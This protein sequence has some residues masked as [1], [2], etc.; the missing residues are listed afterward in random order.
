MQGDPKVIEYLNSALRSE[1]T[2]ISQY[3]LHYRLQDDWGLGH[4]AKKSR[5]E[6]I[7][8][9]N[10]A[11]K[12]MARIL[13]L[14]G[15]PNLQKLDPL[16][17]GQTPKETLECDLAAEQDARALYKEAREYCAEV[18]DHVTKELFDELLADEEGHIDFLET[19]LDLYGRVGDENYAL[20]NASK[21][22]EA[23]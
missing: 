16:R 2:A 12:L 8:E 22:D 19:Q 4:M 3:W 15:H 21:M 20:L 7:E 14:E 17:I 23:G 6:S 11:D 5:E 1:L 13:F 18:G 10:H 9:M